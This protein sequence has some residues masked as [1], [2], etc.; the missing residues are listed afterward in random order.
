MLFDRVVKYK[1][2][3][4]MR[5]ITVGRKTL[6]TINHNH[7]ICIACGSDLNEGFSLCQSCG[8]YQSSWRNELRYWATVTGVFSIIAATIGFSI[9]AWPDIRKALFWRNSLEILQFYESGGLSEISVF[10]TGD[11]PVWISEL[12][13][14][15]G[16]A[17]EQTIPIAKTVQAGKVL[18]E[19]PKNMNGGKGVCMSP[20]EVKKN[21]TAD[22][23]DHATMDEGSSVE[24]V[25][26]RDPTFTKEGYYI[27]GKLNVRYRSLITNDWYTVNS[28]LFAT[29]YV[30]Y[31]CQTGAP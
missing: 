15:A 2:Y 1:L 14:Q 11:G 7:H 6:M 19:A 17:F 23:I 3:D 20:V 28:D 31:N 22:R 5:I 26:K 10:N 21:N 30:H 25:T 24:Y 12:T 29:V 8:S 18:N 4:S 9:S 27:P 13:Y 16:G